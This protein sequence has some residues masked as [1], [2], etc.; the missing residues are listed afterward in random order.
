[1]TE[2]K[3]KEFEVLSA[4]ILQELS[5]KATITLNDSIYGNQTQTSR[6]IDVSIRTKIDGYDILTIVQ[7]KNISI[8]ADVNIVGEFSAVILDV[9]ATRGILICKSGFTATAKVY[10]KNLGIVLLNIH[11]AESRDW[12][13]DLKIP[14]LWREYYIEFE[15]NTPFDSP[16]ERELVMVD[17]RRPSGIEGALPRYSLDSGNNFIDLLSPIMRRWKDGNLQRIIGKKITVPLGENISILTRK[18]DKDE[19]LPIINPSTTYEIKLKRTML[20]YFKSNECRGII[21]YNNDDMFIV[22]NL[23]EI[24]NLPTSPKEDWIEIPDMSKLPFDIKGTV[25]SIEAHAQVETSDVNVQ[26]DGNKIN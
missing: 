13:L 25:L 26:L 21:D 16:D 6:Q 3:W 23:P 20:G 4:K 9:K 19:W 10:A 11:D 18:N 17:E 15:I 8:P 12:N 22:S 7:A 24:G 2:P 5:P 14:V 1:M